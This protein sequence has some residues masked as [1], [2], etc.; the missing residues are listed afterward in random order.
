V[1]RSIARDV[2]LR[3]RDSAPDGGGGGSS[4]RD[5][6][7]LRVTGASAARRPSSQKGGCC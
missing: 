2:M 4:G 6:P 1:F 7:T 5:A 3:L